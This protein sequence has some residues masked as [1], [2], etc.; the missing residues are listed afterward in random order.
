MR[1]PNLDEILIGASPK[2]YICEIH[3]ELYDLVDKSELNGDKESFLNLIAE[4]Y[5]SGKRMSERLSD[6]KKG[7]QNEEDWGDNLDYNED[8]VR[9]ATRMNLLRN[10]KSVNI[11]TIDYCNRKCDWCP[12]K[13]RETSPENLMTWETIRRVIRQLLEYQYAG[14][15]HLFL[16]GEPSLDERIIKIVSLAKTF[17]PKNYIRIVSN[18]SGFDYDKVSNLFKAGLNSLHINHYDGP[19]SDKGKLRDEDFPG[20]SH[21][22]MKTLL[23][24]FYNRA[25]KVNYTPENKAKRC[26]NFNNKLVFNWK[27]DL[28]LCCSDFNSE[29]VFGNIN[30]QPL[31]IIL[32][33][34][35]YR[36]YYYAHR[37]GKAKTLPLCEKC[38]LI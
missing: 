28:I 31:S 8:L 36:E 26:L 16:N 14:D 25:G 34:K 29:V 19:L 11:E 10:V 5:W 23:P 37:E 20:M 18:G 35:K 27:G 12:N 15:I 24:T 9:R 6:L 30:E 4:A 22:G 2:R 17:L 33:S 7:W 38:N 13:N 32:A 3:R 1:A 21:F